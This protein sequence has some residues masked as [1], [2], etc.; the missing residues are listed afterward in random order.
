M[1]RKILTVILII[2][3]LGSSAVLILQHVQQQDAAQAHQA[4]EELASVGGV[5]TPPQV[6]SAQS[7][8]AAVNPLSQLLASPLQAAP[9][10]VQEVLSHLE[11]IPT[12]IAQSLDITA[13]LPVLEDSNAAALKDIDLAALKEINADVIGWFL[14]PGTTISYP[15]LQ[16]TDNEYYLNYTWDNRESFVGSIFM[17]HT[18]NPGLSDFNT[19]IYGHNLGDSHMFSTLTKFKSQSYYQ[20]HP[21]FY[22][23]NAQGIFRYQIIA[24][25][26]AAADSTVFRIRFAGPDS[27]QAY[28]DQVMQH[29][30]IDTGITPT[31]DDRI[32]TLSTCVRGE[33]NNR[34]IVQAR[35]EGQLG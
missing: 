12:A 24:S 20:S 4:A 26:K 34:W 16:G 10:T 33:A 3:F 6:Q 21:Y 27:K 7:A 13:W 19:I 2:V 18:A 35:L 25:Y 8:E 11:Q 30:V 23:V 5:T 29:S 1:L 15:L 28:L 32:V 22:I 14:I 17:D 9:E 31:A